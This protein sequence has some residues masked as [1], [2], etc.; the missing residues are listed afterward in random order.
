MGENEVLSAMTERQFDVMGV[1]RSNLD[2]FMGF[3]W[4]I[5]IAMLLQS[6]LPWQTVLLAQTNAGQVRPM[7]A[8]FAVAI[9]AAAVLAWR[10]IF[11]VPALFS[12]LL[13]VVLVAAHS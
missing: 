1:S 3:G 12:V 8:V 5:S 11:P 7:I 6:I 10:Y 2:F 13:L 4:S 9:A